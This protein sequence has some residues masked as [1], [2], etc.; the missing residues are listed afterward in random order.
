MSSAPASRVAFALC[1]RAVSILVV[2]AGLASPAPAT[3]VLSRITDLRPGDDDGLD[4]LDA[5]VL[6]DTLYFVGRTPAGSPALWAFD[7]SGDPEM[8]ADSDAATPSGLAL[9]NGRLFF[10]GGPSGDIEL[11]SFDPG[12]GSLAEAVDVRPSG[13]ASPTSIVPFGDRVCF[14]A[15][16][17][18]TGREL[19]CWDGSGS[20]DVV[21]LVPG[22]G[23]AS[24]ADLVPAPGRLYVVADVD[25]D[26]RLWSWNGVDPP[27]PVPAP[28]GSDDTFPCCF[29]VLD[30][31][32]YFAAF[33]NQ[34][35]IRLW[36]H[37]GIGPPVAVDAGFEAGGWTG[38]YRQRL[39]AGGA[40][41][42]AGAPDEELWRLGAGGLARISPGATVETASALTVVRDALFALGYP[43]AGDD[44]AIYR[45]CGAG[46]VAALTDPL[47]GDPGA[48][49][50]AMI[51]YAGRLYFAGDD[52]TFGRELWSLASDHVFCDDFESGD[53]G[54]WPPVQP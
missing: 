3:S 42:G 40:D 36:Q 16:G 41:V 7:G 28:V 39:I 17:D 27:E 1:R 38:V 31:W 52:G 51:A 35:R 20:A 32:L 44:F 13:N 6:G 45:F 24:P 30:G 14:L 22:G 46:P 26:A 15:F 49:P 34:F 25:G 33:D 4:R 29:S 10:A 50:E 11:W 8:I 2:L 5:A 21:E 18:G 23:D 9:W 37:D 53:T 47:A 19:F 54:A 43:G 48:D 12:T